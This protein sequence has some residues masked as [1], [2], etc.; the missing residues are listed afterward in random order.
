MMDQERLQREKE[1]TKPGDYLKG[2]EMAVEANYNMIDGV[3]NNKAQPTADLTD[4]QTYEEIQELAPE[5]LLKTE[6]PSILGQL[7]EAKESVVKPFPGSE[8]KPPHLEL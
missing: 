5:T 3:I 2:A 6:N 8:K 1:H 7:K 4:G